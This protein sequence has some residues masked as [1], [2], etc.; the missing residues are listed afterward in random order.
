MFGNGTEIVRLLDWATVVYSIISRRRYSVQKSFSNSHIRDRKKYRKRI[1]ILSDDSQLA[2]SLSLFFGEEFDVQTVEQF[3]QARDIIIQENADLL[4]ID[5]GL[6]DNRISQSL[7]T[8]KSRKKIPV[9]L[10]YVFHEKKLSIESEIRKYADAVFY[11]PVNIID[12]LGQ[13]RLFL[14]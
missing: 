4:L 3:D 8:I 1:L 6:P 10:M 11:K 2:S 13:I 7:S 12:V 5:F 9:I 14:S